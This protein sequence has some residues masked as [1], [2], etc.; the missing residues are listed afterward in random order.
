MNAPESYNIGW[1]TPEILTELK[2]E[3]TKK[4]VFASIWNYWLQA[5][6]GIDISKVL[7]PY[8][9]YYKLWFHMCNEFISNQIRIIVYDDT[10]PISK[11]DQMKFRSYITWARH[12]MKKRII[13][14]L[15]SS[16]HDVLNIFL[17]HKNFWIPSDVC[18]KFLSNSM[19][20]KDNLKIIIDS[21]KDKD[22][23]KDKFLRLMMNLNAAKIDKEPDCNFSDTWI[24]NGWIN[25]IWNLIEKKIYP[26]LCE[27]FYNDE[28]I[29][30]ETFFHLGKFNEVEK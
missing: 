29:G 28:N 20:G 23:D 30:N 11:R 9:G 16:I 17:I 3:R 24:E 4:Q 2:K 5:F 27:T 6:E 25:D 8:K 22:Y 15:T 14:I 7:Q 21:I 10:N 13:G 19:K 18:K 1:I 12:D 26:G